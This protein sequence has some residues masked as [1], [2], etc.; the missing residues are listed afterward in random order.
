MTLTKACD[1]PLTV[2]AKDGKA[3][4][5]PV[6]WGDIVHQFANGLNGP[7]GLVAH[8]YWHGDFIESL[9]EMEVAMAHAGGAGTDQNFPR[10]RGCNVYIFY[11][12]GAVHF[13]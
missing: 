11:F 13:A 4:D 7:G 12:Q 2:S 5:D 6:P 3:A 10:S 9:D 8:D 1:A